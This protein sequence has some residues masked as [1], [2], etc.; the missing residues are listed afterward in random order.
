MV[1]V[2]SFFRLGWGTDA[3]AGIPIGGSGG[4]IPRLFEMTMASAIAML[5]TA[6]ITVAGGGLLFLFSS[7]ICKISVR[8]PEI[9]AFP[10]M[11]SWAIEGV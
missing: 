9:C 10:L 4:G 6:W 1:Y 7:T 8:S 2:D 5:D 3:S 11:L